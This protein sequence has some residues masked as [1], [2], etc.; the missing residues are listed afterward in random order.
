MDDPNIERLLRI[1][2]AI[3]EVQQMSPSE[4]VHELVEALGAQLVAAI[5]CATETRVVRSWETGEAPKRVGSLRAALQATRSIL[6]TCSSATARSWFVGC[7]SRL[8]YVSPLEV[9]REDTEE[10]RARVVRAAVGFA[11]D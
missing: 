2:S 3:E 1:P 11:S 8:G 6:M 5:V 4:V 7:S 9:I 10:G